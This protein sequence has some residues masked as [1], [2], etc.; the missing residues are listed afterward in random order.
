MTNFLI[1]GLGLIAGRLFRYFKA[2]PAD[3]HKGINAW[4]LYIALPAV[5]F[6]YLPKVQW[7]TDMILPAITPIIVALGGYLA[8]SVYSKKKNLS[9]NT[10]GAMKLAAGFCNTS[11]IGFPL[12]MAYYS[13]QDLSV[14]IITDQVSF[15]LVST[16]AI[17]T[18]V[19]SS[20]KGKVTASL[21]LRKLFTFPPL[22]GCIAALTLPRLFDMSAFDDFFDKLAGTVG[23]LALFS[24][25][26]QLR[27]DGWQ[28]E[29]KNILF[30][31]GYKL[32][33]APALVLLVAYF[34]KAPHDISKISVFEAAMPT[35]ITS[36]IIAEEYNLNP[37]FV[38]LTI[39]TGIILGFI[40]TGFWYV[41]LKMAPY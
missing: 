32:L 40:T 37:K 38:S 3:N 5:S 39:G 8:V 24:V 7:T 36:G 14:A 6:K 16:L 22:I 34:M 33:V 20:G 31:H 17:T 4:I 19:T 27:F 1:I 26:L 41:V 13:E 9:V 28:E 35:L 21:L 25:G 11:F 15:M 23:P 18:A 12:I 10:E 29:I 2:I 30:I